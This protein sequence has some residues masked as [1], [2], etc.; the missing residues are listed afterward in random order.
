[1]TG[2]DEAWMESKVVERPVRERR[3]T[4]RRRRADFGSIRASRRD[5]E[6]LEFV[7]EQ[8]AVTLPQLARLMNRRVETA[9]SLRDRWTRAGWARSAQL[10]IAVP[11]FVWLT[12]AGAAVG[13]SPFR[14]W[15]PNPGL[16]THIQAVTDIR[17]LL[18]RDMRHGEWECERSVAR[19]LARSGNRRF[20]GHLPDGVLH[21]DA[22]P[23]AVEVELTLKSRVRLNEIVTALT[24]EYHEVWYF[25]PERLERALTELKSIAPRQNIRISRYE[26]PPAQPTLRSP[27]ATGDATD[28]RNSPNS[29]MPQKRLEQ[30]EF[31]GGATAT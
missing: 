16:A 3:G 28:R 18:E 22:G 17:I 20:R 5:F 31:W 9:R 12:R 27:N 25:V 14:V 8:Y 30:T 19:G 7:G 10:A 13:S 26:T 21:T 4:A 6:L 29:S 24:A 23:V 11:S 15:E 1:M 2:W